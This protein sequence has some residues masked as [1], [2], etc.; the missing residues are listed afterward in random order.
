MAAAKRHDN[1]T[2][3]LLSN[4]IGADSLTS[5]KRWDSKE[6]KHIFVDC[7][8]II[9]SYNRSRGGVD[10]LDKMGFSYRFSNRSKRWYIYLFWHTLKILA[11]NAWFMHK[12][13]IQQH[14]RPPTSL[15]KFL[16][17]LE[18]SLILLNKRPPGRPSIQNVT[19]FKIVCLNVPRD[20][21]RDS[22]EHW[23]T[24]NTKQ[25]RCKACPGGYTYVLCA[26]CMVMLCFNKDRNCF[27][28]FHQ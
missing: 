16:S 25:N 14:K 28:S 8:A 27:V 10:L 9:P 7:P 5:V 20:V 4:C 11:V 15:R 6:K 17:E 1:R 12:K 22:K 21:R 24:W 2:V 23:P 13:I 26:K 18:T 19:P 3:T